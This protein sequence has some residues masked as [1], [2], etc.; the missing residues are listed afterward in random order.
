MC[1]VHSNPLAPYHHQGSYVPPGSF[2]ACIDY[3]CPEN[4]FD[5]DSDASTP[6]ISCCED[7]TSPVG[8]TECTTWCACLNGATCSGTRDALV[9]NCAVGY[10]GSLCE[11]P[12]VSA[13]PA[14]QVRL[15]PQ[16]RQLPSCT[17]LTCNPP[18]LSNRRGQVTTPRHLALIAK[19]YAEGRTQ[20]LYCPPSFSHATMCVL[21]PGIVRRCW[22]HGSLH[23]LCARRD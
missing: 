21:T 19:W 5:H 12:L 6:C 2:G 22:H 20:P 7:E 13:C 11:N 8:A 15:P 9:C 17:K 18:R 23:S 4:T 10:T 1:A 3:K 14:G 16:E